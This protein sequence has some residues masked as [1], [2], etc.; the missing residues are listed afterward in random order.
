MK[1]AG[2]TLGPDD[3]NEIFSFM[4]L[5]SL[6]FTFDFNFHLSQPTA[7]I[8]D[9]THRFN[10]PSQTFHFLNNLISL[11]KGLRFPY[12]DDQTFQPRVDCTTCYYSVLL[13]REANTHNVSFVLSLRQ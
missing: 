3:N 8:S 5:G 4:N 13:C 12:A 10:F 1:R 7:C 6:S 9:C 2:V 11:T